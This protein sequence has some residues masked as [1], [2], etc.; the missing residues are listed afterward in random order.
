MPLVAIELLPLERPWEE[1][2]AGGRIVSDVC[3]SE[4]VPLN[5]AWREHWTEAFLANQA[6]ALPDCLGE[7][8]VGITV[9]R[10]LAD[11][12]LVYINTE[13][14]SAILVE[15]KKQRGSNAKDALCQLARNLS[16]ARRVLAA[17]NLKAIRTIA[18][19]E[20]GTSQI[21]RAKST[22]AW[23]FLVEEEANPGFI[24]HAGA[25][26]RDGRHYFLLKHDA[27]PI[28]GKGR[29]SDPAWYLELQ[30]IAG[31][32]SEMLPDGLRLELYRVGSMIVIRCTGDSEVRDSYLGSRVGAPPDPA[33]AAFLAIEQYLNRHDLKT[34]RI[35]GQRLECRVLLENVDT[36]DSAQIDRIRLLLRNAAE[37]GCAA[38]DLSG[39]ADDGRALGATLEDEAE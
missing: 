30:G 26:G 35:I 36:K 34:R 29:R 33:I 31:N 23:Q 3:V 7:Q 10:Q 22:V 39:S 16:S 21:A 4:L 8:S 38:L 17:H 24:V 20:W 1:C 12:D 14:G 37:A 27:P 5:L 32:L 6:R 18:C 13:K 19:G 25:M 15:L 28:A 2:P 11:I 9:W